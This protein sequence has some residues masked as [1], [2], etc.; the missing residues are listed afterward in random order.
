MSEVEQTTEETEDDRPAAVVGWFENAKLDEEN[1][2]ERMLEMSG[3]KWQ[4]NE[5]RRYWGTCC[6][7]AIFPDALDQPVEKAYGDMERVELLRM[8]QYPFS[9]GRSRESSLITDYTVATTYYVWYK[10]HRFLVGT[11][12]GRYII[13]FKFRGFCFEDEYAYSSP[14][15]TRDEHI[16][17]AHQTM[18]EVFELWI[19]KWEMRGEWK[20]P[21]T[22]YDKEKDLMREGELSKHAHGVN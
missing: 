22:I 16:G 14:E 12:G 19:E 13:G 8:T 11:Y 2:I 4:K 10:E 1:F 6:D 7:D 20:Q 3:L 21:L 18:L 9:G 15:F 17:Y 5:G